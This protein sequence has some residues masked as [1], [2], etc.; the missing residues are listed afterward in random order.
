MVPFTNRVVPVVDL[1][2]GRLVIDP[3]EVLLDNR[4]VEAEKDE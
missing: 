1:E 4:P 2:A 3:P